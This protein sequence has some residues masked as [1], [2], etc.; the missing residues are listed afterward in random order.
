MIV[1]YRPLQVVVEV[2]S[3]LLTRT[4]ET[5]SSK[6]RR[7]HRFEPPFLF[8]I[9]LKNLQRNRA[10]PLRPIALQRPSQWQYHQIIREQEPCKSS[11]TVSSIT[12]KREEY[13]LNVRTSESLLRTLIYLVVFSLLAVTDLDT[14]LASSRTRAILWSL[15]DL[16]LLLLSF[17]LSYLCMVLPSA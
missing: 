2:W 1:F 14:W 3:C 13:I 12:R 10:A 9:H 16:A 7:V 6:D 4:L 5:A 8:K 11:L 15:L 17:W